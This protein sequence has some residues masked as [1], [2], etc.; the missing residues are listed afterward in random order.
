MTAPASSSATSHEDWT[1]PG[2]FSVCPGVHRIPLPL[3]NDG[4]H[5]VNVYA[6][7]DG[8]GLV[9]ID[10]GWALA[11]AHERLDAALGSIGHELGDVRQFL[12]THV[13]RDHY[14]MAVAL[15]RLFGSRIALGRGEEV[16]LRQII[17]HGQPEGP[18]VAEL[19]RNGATLVIDRLQALPRPDE[20]S[21]WELP[22]GWLADG[23]EIALADRTLRVVHTPG[24]TR[25]HVVFA[26][27]AGGLLFAGDHVLP[28]ITPSIGFESARA[29]LP[30]GD[31]LG[32][33]RRVRA[34]PDLRLLP[35]HG[36][37]ADST[38]ARVDEL[39][40][41]HDQRLDEALRAIGGGAGTAYQ[42]AR[43]LR[44]TRRHRALDDLDPVNQMLAVMETAA[45]LDVL[46]REGRLR[47]STDDGV[48]HYHP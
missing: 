35:A 21:D 26:D 38:H 45:H 46:V 9:F 1:E 2:I 17:D 14:T 20:T 8:D 44:W 10:S 24:H 30:L 28:H 25:G 33:L 47:S 36:P 48:V 34:L 27:F 29:A 40:V 4:L 32:S 41:H 31:F 22:D 5:A 37:V 39:V 18:H 43:V 42:V 6:I 12:V 13:H 16:N 3:P 23:S 11:L 15:R 7:D 19:R